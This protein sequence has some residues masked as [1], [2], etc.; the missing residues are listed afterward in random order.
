MTMLSPV[1]RFVRA[2]R[3]PL[4]IAAL[5]AVTVA[6]TVAAQEG[7]PAAGV[8]GTPSTELDCE[9]TPP[10]P[11]TTYTIVSEESEA[12]YRARE[13]LAS[14]GA[15]DAI[16]RTNAFIGQIHFD[17]AGLP[18][19]CSRFD[20]DMRTLVSDNARRDNYLY[21]NTLET[22]TFP[23]A[24]FILTDVEG[25]DG[26]LPEG[27]ATTVTLIGNLTIKDVTR[28]VAWEATVTRD[29][30]TLS[31]SAVTEFDMPEYEIEPPVVGPVVGINETVALEI[32]VTA[33]AG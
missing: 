18:L 13:E 27:E 24:T 30:E 7:T 16:G 15:Q 3:P 26:A 11:A 4:A 21:G 32:D 22:G 31:G 17:E 8:L 10:S 20:V 6:P 5:A 1:A 33:N 23:L 29:G 14:I 2:A 19:A 25:L 12:R 28:L 9:A